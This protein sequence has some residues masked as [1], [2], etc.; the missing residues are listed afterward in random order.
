M[1]N[2]LIKMGVLHIFAPK[3]R[4]WERMPLA[5]DC[6]AFGAYPLFSLIYATRREKLAY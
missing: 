2:A 4:K 5:S 1:C 3:V 6:C